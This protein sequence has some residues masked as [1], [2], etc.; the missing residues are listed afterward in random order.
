MNNE[1]GL[2]GHVAA[3]QQRHVRHPPIPVPDDEV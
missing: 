2:A 3:D 1:G